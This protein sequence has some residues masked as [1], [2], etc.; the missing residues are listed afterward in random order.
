MSFS[1]LILS[2]CA[3]HVLLVITSKARLLLMALVW[4]LYLLDSILSLAAFQLN[5]NLLVHLLPTTSL[6]TSISQTSRSHGNN[7]LLEHCPKN[8]KGQLIYNWHFVWEGIFGLRMCLIWSAK[9]YKTLKPNNVVLYKYIL[10]K[11]NSS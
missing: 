3:V 8:S 1:Q 7:I 9:T 11:L 4:L 2:V 6:C 10:L 5:E